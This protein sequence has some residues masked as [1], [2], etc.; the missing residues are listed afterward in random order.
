[1][2]STSQE[3]TNVIKSDQAKY[4]KVIKEAGI[5]MEP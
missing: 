4:V 1:V 2:T 5:K 3:F